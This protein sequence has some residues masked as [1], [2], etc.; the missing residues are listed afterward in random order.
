MPFLSPNQQCQS[1]QQFSSPFHTDKTG[2]GR[3][4]W[5]QWGWVDSWCPSVE[6]CDNPAT[7]TR[8]GAVSRL[9]RRPH[10]NQCSW[11]THSP[12]G[13]RT[14]SRTERCHCQRA[15]RS[16]HNAVLQ[17]RCRAAEWEMLDCPANAY[18]THCRGRCTH[19]MNTNS[20]A[21]LIL[22]SII[23]TRLDKIQSSGRLYLTSRALR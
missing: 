1:K 10:W 9:W 3:P 8:L 16:H 14:C 18:M 7:R 23:I 11:Q 20:K 5:R 17:T 4:P 22:L 12:A 6:W 15:D 19:L 13:C 21:H 2:S